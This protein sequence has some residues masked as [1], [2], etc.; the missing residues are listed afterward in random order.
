MIILG[1][2]V[3]N[4]NW[5]QPPEALLYNIE[6]LHKCIPFPFAVNN[7]L[8]AFKSGCTVL[9]VRLLTSCRYSFHQSDCNG[10]MSVQSVLE[11][12]HLCW[13]L[14]QF[15]SSFRSQKYYLFWSRIYCMHFCLGNVYVNARKLTSMSG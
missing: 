13:L 9:C 7:I 1:R 2:K 5:N 10:F 12:F 8:P 15:Q 4:K 11:V 3:V 14:S 6:S